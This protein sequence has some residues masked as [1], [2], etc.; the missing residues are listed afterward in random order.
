VRR[1]IVIGL[2]AVVVIGAVAAYFGWES[3]IQK[4]ARRELMAFRAGVELGADADSVRKQ[5]D[6]TRARRLDLHEIR[7]NLWVVGTPLQFGAGNWVLYISFQDSMVHELKVRTEDSK[8][9]RPR[10]APPDKALGTIVIH[11]IPP[12]EMPATVDY[13]GYLHC[14]L[15]RRI[16]PTRNS[17]VT[18]E[19]LKAD[20]KLQ[21]CE[22][23][24]TLDGDS[25]EYRGVVAKGRKFEFCPKL[26]AIGVSVTEVHAT[27]VVICVP[28]LVNPSPYE[29]PGP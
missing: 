2:L 4:E 16:K 20:E 1:R 21:E 11:S 27:N 28:G 25:R 10:G 17:G 26:A 9:Y 22:F 19:L 8:D 29:V 5:F 15:S 24:V 23:R 18:F 14:G 13:A 3:L 7:T 6:A 12:G